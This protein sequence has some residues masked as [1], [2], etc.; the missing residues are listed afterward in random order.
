MGYYRQLRFRPSESLR[1]RITVPTVTFAS[2]DDS[3]VTSDDYR[4]AKRMFEGEY[5][6]EEVPGGHF[7][8]REHPEVF[9]ERLLAHL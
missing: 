6:I 8:H 3:V 4:G 5:V 9:A 2:L 1:R 7:P